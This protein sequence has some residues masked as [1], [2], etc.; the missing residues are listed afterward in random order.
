[1]FVDSNI[2]PGTEAVSYV[3]RARRGDQVSIPSDTVS[4]TSVCRATA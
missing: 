4:S 2:P 1:M 3:L